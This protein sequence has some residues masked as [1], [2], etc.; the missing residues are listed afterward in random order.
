MKKKRL[1]AYLC[2]KQYF[3]TKTKAQKAIL[4]GDVQLNGETIYK[5]AYDI[6]ESK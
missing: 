6:D 5:P 1:D 4:A 2:E 3:E